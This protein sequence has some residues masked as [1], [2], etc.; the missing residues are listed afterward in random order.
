MWIGT[1]GDS[2]RDTYSQMILYGFGVEIGILVSPDVKKKRLTVI[3]VAGFS[4]YPICVM[5]LPFI[6]SYWHGLSIGFALAAIADTTFKGIYAV[7]RFLPRLLTAQKLTPSIQKPP[8]RSQAI[9]VE[10]DELLPLLEPFLLRWGAKG[11]LGKDSSRWAKVETED[12]VDLQRSARLL[13]DQLLQLNS[14]HGETWDFGLR[15][16][17]GYLSEELRKFGVVEPT[18]GE[19][20]LD[21]T[22]M[23]SHGRSAFEAARAVVAWIKQK[24]K[25]MP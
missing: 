14:K 1:W 3:E 6:P 5:T 2:L 15:N 4:V 11:I 16:Q 12:R 22:A 10:Y 13:S 17:I 25:E 24:K 21:F 9:T 23:D 19:K 7:D 20:E 8:K 18:V